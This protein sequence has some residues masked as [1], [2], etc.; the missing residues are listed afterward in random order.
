MEGTPHGPDEI[1]CASL[2]I[3]IKKVTGLNLHQAPDALDVGEPLEIQLCYGAVDARV[4][5]SISVTEGRS[6]S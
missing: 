5:K 3:P 6:Q 1:S 2:D 4:V